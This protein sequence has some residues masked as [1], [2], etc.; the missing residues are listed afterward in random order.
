SFLVDGLLYPALSELLQ[1]GIC[2]VVVADE[3]KRD[4]SYNGL[5]EDKAFQAKVQL[6][7]EAVG[8]L[9]SSVLQRDARLTPEADREMR[10][11]LAHLEGRLNVSDL[12]AAF[13]SI[14]IDLR[15]YL[16]SF[17]FDVMLKQ[18]PNY[19]Q[20]ERETLLDE[21]SKVFATL[22]AAG[23]AEQA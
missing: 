9:I 18:L 23:E 13:E 1:F 2:G 14:S 15:P 22:R 8:R 21:Y 17:S 16:Q 3:L 6:T 7:L 11:L 12:W 4:L 20:L 19:S 10:A 5:L